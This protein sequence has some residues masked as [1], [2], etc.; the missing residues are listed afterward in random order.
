MEG[1]THKIDKDF[2][3]SDDTVNEYGFILKTDG[4]QGD[5]FKQ[6]PIG[7][8][9][10]TNKDDGALVKW[11]DIRV[12]DNK[13]LAKPVINMSH[14][15]AQRTIDEV[16]SGFIGG[17]SV[18][19][20]KILDKATQIDPNTGKK[21]TVVTKWANKQ[22]DLVTLPGNRGVINAAP[23]LF[24]ANDNEIQLSDLLND[25][26]HTVMDTTIPSVVLEALS[27][28]DSATQ[29]EAVAAINALVAKANKAELELKELKDAADDAEVEKVIAQGLAD[30]KLTVELCD[31]LRI[32]YKGK[33]VELKDLIGAMPEYKSIT[34]SLKVED[35]K[36]SLE[37]KELSDK[38]FDDLDKA[39]RLI[40]CRDKFP[41][42]FKEKY[43]G[44]FGQQKWDESPY[45]AKA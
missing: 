22:A 29:T 11:D 21:I 7:Y 23:Q 32:Q 42:L 25:K 6:L 15:R 1:K 34:E 39:N 17:A 27:L 45:A 18:A 35:D 13:I 38:S 33:P 4:W 16:E 5:V 8:F 14:P 19:G 44:K 30:K 41:N 31:K 28:S 36:D 12:V 20:L 24:D 37:Y 9:N 40:E 10:H 2:V 43:I 26:N 3:L